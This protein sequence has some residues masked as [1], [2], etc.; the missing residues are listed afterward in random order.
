MQV[1]RTA[2]KRC[3]EVCKS[4]CDSTTY[5]IDVNNMPWP[6]Y[7][8]R[9]KIYKHYI[10]GTEFANVTALRNITK[11]MKVN[12][13]EAEKMLRD[14]DALP[15]AFTLVR[16][17]FI[18]HGVASLEEQPVYT[19]ASLMGALGGILNLWVGLSFITIIE[20]LDCL[21]SCLR[22]RDQKTNARANSK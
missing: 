10:N 5:L 22:R 9:V 17:R 2:V 12:V 1:T 7:S 18:T 11:M 8:E 20:I 6:H 4:S 15:R 3:S 14:T 21:M 13:K 16:V 19:V